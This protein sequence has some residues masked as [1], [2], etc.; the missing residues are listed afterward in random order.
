MSTQE[1]HS[2]PGHHHRVDA[3]VAGLVPHTE[4]DLGAGQLWSG[5]ERS[6]DKACRVHPDRE[7]GA[8]PLARTPGSH[9]FWRA[10]RSGRLL[11]D[12]V[13]T[14]VDEPLGLNDVGLDVVGQG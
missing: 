5:V 11:A 7:R 6:R 14:L 4:H 1:W 3:P 13:S 10:S 12:Q 9:Y 8:V 2:W